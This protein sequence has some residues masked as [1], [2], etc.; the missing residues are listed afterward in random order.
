MKKH[1]LFVLAAIIACTTS[2]TATAEENTNFNYENCIYDIIDENQDQY[3]GYYYD[4]DTDTIHIVPYEYATESLTEGSITTD[5][6]TTINVV[7][8]N[9]A[10]YSLE[11]LLDGSDKLDNYWNQ[12]EIVQVGVRQIDN[13]LFVGCFNLTDYKKENIKRISGIDNIEFKEFSEDDVWDIGDE[14]SEPDSEN[15]IMGLSSTVELKYGNTLRNT[16]TE[17]GS[18][19]GAIAT[20]GSR[21]FVVTTGHNEKN[22]NIVTVMGPSNDTINTRVGKVIWN[23]FTNATKDT[24]GY[25]TNDASIIEIDSNNVV[26]TS[27]T[28]DGVEIT[29]PA[30]PVEGKTCKIYSSSKLHR[31]TVAIRGTNEKV[32]W[33]DKNCTDDYNKPYKNMILLDNDIYESKQPTNG[34]SGAPLCMYYF[35]SDGNVSTVNLC[36]IYKGRHEDSNGNYQ[37]YATRWDSITSEYPMSLY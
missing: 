18:T 15:E 9:P 17:A 12:L 26:Q 16:V 21:K 10:K 31:P 36:G 3:G 1:I 37:F 27:Y 20:Y 33:F 24:Q 13:G 14:N 34:D 32:K 30:K 5:I 11:Q 25:V 2:I 7:F 28:D 29:A 19:I 4:D 23:S 8:D 6:N 35:D 22:G